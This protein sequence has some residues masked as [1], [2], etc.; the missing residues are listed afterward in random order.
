MDHA[1]RRLCTLAKHQGVLP[2]R[3]T[4]TFMPSKRRN[5][6]SHSPGNRPSKVGKH[7]HT[8]KPGKSVRK[9]YSKARCGECGEY[10]HTTG[11]DNTYIRRQ[12]GAARAASQL[13]Q[14]TKLRIDCQ[15]PRMK[16]REDPLTPVRK[17]RDRGNCWRSHVMFMTRELPVVP[18]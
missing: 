2:P 8:A 5:T 16:T 4:Q 10:G 6:E 15:A 9:D 7:S 1:I 12:H 14:A 3:N 18:R 11:Y 13:P 17:P